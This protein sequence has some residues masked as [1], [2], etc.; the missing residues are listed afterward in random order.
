MKID[1]TLVKPTSLTTDGNDL[2]ITVDLLYKCLDGYK[3]NEF[4]IY[5]A[6]LVQNMG[7]KLL[8]RTYIIGLKGASKKWWKKPISMHN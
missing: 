2:E 5:K 7:P 4:Q 8:N 6:K 1:W 3:S